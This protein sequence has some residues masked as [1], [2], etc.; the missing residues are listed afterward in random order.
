M[1]KPG[2]FRHLA[3]A[4]SLFLSNFVVKQK[5]FIIDLLVLNI[6]RIFLKI[7]QIL[8]LIFIQTKLFQNSLK[9]C[10]I[11]TFYC[12]FWFRDKSSTILA[13]TNMHNFG[14]V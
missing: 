2:S 6:V 4:R 1:P 10:K 8:T 13:F 12:F 3:L 5:L 9:L 14:L 11:S 7:Q